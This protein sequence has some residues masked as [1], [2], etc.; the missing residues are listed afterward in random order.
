VLKCECKRARCD[1]VCD[2]LVDAVETDKRED[3]TKSVIV[4]VVVVEVEA[5]IIFF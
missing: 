2:R 1:A 4:G 5:A 3:G